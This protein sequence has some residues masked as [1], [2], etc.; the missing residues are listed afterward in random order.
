MPD[1]IARNYTCLKRSPA[2]RVIDF[3]SVENHPSRQRP[4]E[5]F[6]A[7]GL[8]QLRSGLESFRN[9]FGDVPVH[10]P[11]GCIREPQIYVGLENKMHSL[12]EA[13]S[14]LEFVGKLV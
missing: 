8:P 6:Q 7:A 9:I 11:G 2:G 1:N 4:H 10:Y 12:H 5:A 14:D 3:K 13:I